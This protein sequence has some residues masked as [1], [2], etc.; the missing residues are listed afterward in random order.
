[1]REGDVIDLGLGDKVAIVTGGS[2]GLKQKGAALPVRTD[3]SD[4]S[5]VAALFEQV[6]STFGRGDIL[7]NNAGVNPIMVT[8]FPQIVCTQA[9]FNVIGK[10]R[11]E[12]VPDQVIRYALGLFG[13]PIAPIDPEV[14]AR[15]LASSRAKE[16]AAEPLPPSLAELRKKIGQN[17]SDDEFLLRAT[18]PADQVDA[19]RAAPAPSGR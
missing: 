2:G 6:V 1:V 13:R 14:K 7:V 12:K 15:I 11:Y 16:I 4:E 8:P 3:V 9:L 18:M 17:L 19:M 5:S 10:E